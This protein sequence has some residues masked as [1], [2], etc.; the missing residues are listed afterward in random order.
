[1]AKD[2]RNMTLE[3]LWELFP[4]TLSPHRPEWKI[5]AE[6][7]ISLLVNRLSK[8]RPSINHIGSTAIDGILSKPIIDLLVEVNENIG[9]DDI[10]QLLEANG[11]T[12][13]SA[14]GRRLSFNKGYTIQ[15]YAERVF[16]LHLRREGDNTEINFR[17]YLN[18]H[19]DIAKK[20]EALKISLLPRYRNDRDAYTRAKTGF[21]ERINR[22]AADMRDGRLSQPE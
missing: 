4:I 7:E 19:S 13:M 16:H 18:A 11:Y 8:F 14:A 3:E 21:I 20:Y 5:W 9:F 2:L 1:M 6:E 22:M 17:N 15:G 12:C 10:R